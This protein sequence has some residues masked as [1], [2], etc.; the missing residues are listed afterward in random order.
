MVMMNKFE[1]W[2]WGLLGG[3][4]G[5]G[6][7]AACAWLGMAGA[8]A[9]GL[10]VPALNFKALGVIFLSGAVSN[11][12]A[13]LKQSPLPALSGGGGAEPVPITNFPTPKAGFVIPRWLWAMAVFNTLASGLLLLSESGCVTG[14]NLDPA[15]VYQSDTF[16]ANSDLLLVSARSNL[17][18]FVTFEW[19]NRGPLRAAHLESLT[20]AA[21]AVRTNVATWFAVAELARSAYVNARAL[22]ATNATRVA[23]SNT[24]ALQVISIQS[25]AATAQS[26]KTSAATAATP[27]PSL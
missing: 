11:A 22:A 25:Q 8:K 5:G 26:L 21:D 4:I 18:N 24:L 12:L 15:G 23:A 3:A 13:F 14:L 1:L 17:D 19:Q 7:T 10:D 6:A 16:L 20:L 27:I 9:V 2:A